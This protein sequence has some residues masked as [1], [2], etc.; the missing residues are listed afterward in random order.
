MRTVLFVVMCAVAACGGKGKDAESPGGDTAAAQDT[1]SLYERLGGT[2]G[3]RA[4]VKEFVAVTGSDPRISQFFANTDIPRLEEM[5]VEHICESTGGP[6]K[7]TGKSMKE[8]HTGMK[9]RKEHF[10]AFMDDLAKTL[11]KMNV[12]AREKGEV[13]AFF[14]SLEADV[15]E[16][17]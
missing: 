9:V 10:D 6:C 14:N 17:E 16:P 2:D 1:R 7:Y 15:V 3:I 12:P 11:D 8:S 5:M 4:V 13:L